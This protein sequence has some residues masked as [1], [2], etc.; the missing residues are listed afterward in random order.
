MATDGGHWSDGNGHGSSN[1]L[2]WILRR[3]KPKKRRTIHDQNDHGSMVARRCSRRNDG[4]TAHHAR[5]DGVDEED[6]DEVVLGLRVTVGL[7]TIFTLRQ[8]FEYVN[9]PFTI[10]DSVYGS[11]FYM[12]TGFH[13]FHVF[14]GTVFL[15]VCRWRVTENHMTKQHHFGLEAAAWY[16][17][18]VDVVWLFLF[19]AVYWWSA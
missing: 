5:A 12:A 11:T 10:S 16:W 13:G 3:R 18:F 14:I 2:P 19:V 9:A 7:A 6:R 17:H 1:V 15:A 4:R 8:V